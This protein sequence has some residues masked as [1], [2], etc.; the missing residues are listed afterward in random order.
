MQTYS[1]YVDAHVVACGSVKEIRVRQAPI[2]GKLHADRKN[3]EVREY[4][5]RGWLVQS[6]MEALP[7][8]TDPGLAISA[9][10]W[11]PVQAYYAVHGVGMAV[12]QALGAAEPDSHTKFCSS[13][14]THV[15]PRGLPTPLNA[16]V[17]GG[18]DHFV[19]G[20]VSV[21][22][23]LVDTLS[24]LAT[25]SPANAE[26]FV[27]KA[28]KTTREKNLKERYKKEAKKRR[29]RGTTRRNL[30]AEEKAS[31]AFALHPTTIFDLLYRMRLRSNYDDPDMFI[32]GQADRWSAKRR[33]ENVLKLT[34]CI[35]ACLEVIVERK[36]G[37][38]SFGELKSEFSKRIPG[39]TEA[40]SST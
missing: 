24:V 15:V 18:V 26:L 10:L 3:A 1:N 30:P 16:T 12:L 38:S 39:R 5:F 19:Y 25:V 2:L 7:V 37:S 35:T 33:Y 36:I 13:M 6:A 14:A 22:S 40:S 34:Q 23:K 11:A 9:K 31:I 21:D 29:S 20:G 4:L 28:L 8:S 17:T 32:Y 27:A